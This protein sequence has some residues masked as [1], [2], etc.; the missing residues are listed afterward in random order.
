MSNVNDS[1]HRADNEPD[2]EVDAASRVDGEV[3]RWVVVHH[4]TIWHP[5]TDI[6][7]LDEQ[8][9]VLVEIAGM[10]DAD[11]NVVLQG[12]QLIISGVRQCATSAESAYH[13]LEIRFGE[14]RTEI[15][16]PIPVR[17]EEVT[18]TYRDGFLRVELPRMHRR[19]VQIV[20]VDTDGNVDE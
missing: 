3:R 2:S 16:L 15:N 19:K 20:N 1:P 10:R 18:A 5:P 12:Q 11:F 13:Q 9:V 4:A 8:I 7:E 17:R 14:F 6:Y